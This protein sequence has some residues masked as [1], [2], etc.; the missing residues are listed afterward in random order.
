[1]YELVGRGLWTW[2]IGYSDIRRHDA[3][4]RPPRDVARAVSVRRAPSTMVLKTERCSFSGL[5]VYPGHGTRLTK[6]DS[7]RCV[8][9]VGSRIS[10]RA[11][12]AS[13]VSHPSPTPRSRGSS[14]ARV[15]ETR[16]ACEDDACDDDGAMRESGE[17]AR[18]IRAR[19]RRD[20]LE[21]DGWRDGARARGAIAQRRWVRAL[22]SM[23]R[24][25]TTTRARALSFGVL[26]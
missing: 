22:K 20:G 13:G 16:D 26:T 25:M 19:V 2:C 17:G 6:I 18:V 10:A 5:R 9:R 14:W 11:R 7:V 8:R 4:P 21:V 24:R 15:V 1:V 3:P 23:G 12:V